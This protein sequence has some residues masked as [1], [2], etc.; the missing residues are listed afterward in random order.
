M[1]IEEFFNHQVQHAL[2]NYNGNYGFLDFPAIS[3][4]SWTAA[5]E[6]LALRNG[7]TEDP[8]HWRTIEGTLDDARVLSNDDE[9]KL[10]LWV[11][12]RASN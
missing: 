11:R 9:S 6:Q 1:D 2:A 10:Q 8:L 4:A 7:A 12:H 5:D 3:F